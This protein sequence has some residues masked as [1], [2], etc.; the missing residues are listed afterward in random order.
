MLQSGVWDEPVFLGA[1]PAVRC[2]P[3]GRRVKV[4][5][6]PACLI[7]CVACDRTVDQRRYDRLF[8]EAMDAALA[9][10]S[11]ETSV[12]PTLDERIQETRDRLAVLEA[13]KADRERLP[14]DQRLARML[15]DG[16]LPV[17]D[18][19]WAVAERAR[20]L[21]EY[22]AWADRILSYIQGRNVDHARTLVGIVETGRPV[23]QSRPQG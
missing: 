21:T 4:L 16:H 8:N 2:V 9:Y 20:L 19:P 17:G 6:R 10:F 23:T 14:A 1:L 22:T 5:C 11:Q 7:T 3:S 12:M 15:A 18:D 13:E